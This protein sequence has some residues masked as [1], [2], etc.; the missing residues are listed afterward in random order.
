MSGSTPY[1]APDPNAT[2]VETRPKTVRP[3]TWPLLLMAAI[4]LWG[5]FGPT[6]LGLSDFVRFGSL[7]MGAL[8]QV[9]LLLLWA[10][11]AF[12]IP[13]SQRLAALG[14]GIGTLVLAFLLQHPQL[15]I[16]I[17]LFGVPVAVIV[18]AVTVLAT[19]TMAWPKRRW[20]LA[21]AWCLPILAWLSFRSDGFMASF[22]PQ[23]RWRWSP[24]SE[25]KLAEEL[26]SRENSVRGRELPVSVKLQKG[27]WARF[28]G[29]G[30]NGQATDSSLDLSKAIVSKEVW[31]RAGGPSW[32]S[33]IE[34]DGLLFTLEQR[35]EQEAIV[36]LD[37]GTGEE[38]W[39]YAYACRYEDPTQV[40]GVGPRGTP[41]FANGRIYAVGA[42]GAVNVLHAHNGELVWHR[43]LMQDTGGQVPQW[44]I[45][46]SPVI[47]GNKCF[48]MSSSEKAGAVDCVCYDAATGEVLWK[49]EGAGSTYSSPQI[50]TLGNV[51]QVLIFSTRMYGERI[52][53][54]IVSR[55]LETGRQLW[56]YASNGSGNAMVTPLVIDP[57]T[58]LTFDGSKGAIALRVQPPESGETWTVEPVWTQNKM[59]SEFSD[60][61]IQQG[62]LLGLSKGMLTAVD[63]DHG[64][65]LWKKYR[66]GGGQI[67]GLADQGAVLAISE[68]G[69]LLLVRTSKAKAETLLEW[70]GIEGKTWNHPILVGNR[71]YVRNSEEI[72]CHE[73][74]NP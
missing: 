73:L 29:N 35:G 42:K 16:S 46:T 19:R 50:A 17:L 7:A 47:E 3:R 59:L 74:S 56:E 28:R 13:W 65:V 61:V 6:L 70:Q 14:I 5:L 10:A 36:C 31:K 30:N 26:K 44:G 41:V 58:L 2:P 20:F 63:L 71:V 4:A 22:A 23:L 24:T 49:G 43:D 69:S 72:A 53:Q 48:V 60:G 18:M 62:M 54:F 64:K 9:L 39:V 37:A 67:I 38:V 55:D 34:V 57:S 15:G 27:D 1:Q 51:P 32:S 66:L 8:A 33:L 11:F 40:S 68:Q 52:G 21:A 12:R 25:S 45:S